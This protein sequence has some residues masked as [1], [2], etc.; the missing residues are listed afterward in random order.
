MPKRICTYPGCRLLVDAGRC[1]EHSRQK[2][3]PPRGVVANREFYW[4]KEWRKLRAVHLRRE[5]LC[6]IARICTG[7]PA[8]EVDHVVPISAGGDRLDPDNLQSACKRCHTWKTFNVDV[9]AIRAHKE[10]KREQIS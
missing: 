3:A 5:P 7:V 10:S 9:D 4:S 8:T 1:A 6:Q 2:Y